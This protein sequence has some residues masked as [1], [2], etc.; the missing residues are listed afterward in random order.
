MPGY[1]MWYTIDMNALR[2]EYERMNALTP[3]QARAEYEAERNEKASIQ[4]VDPAKVEEIIKSLDKRGA[5][6]EDI[7]M[8]DYF[9]P[10]FGE[11]TTF[12]GIN[13]R[14]FIGNMNM[15]TNYVSE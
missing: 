11:R 2:K 6:V 9:N 4:Q 13:I 1:G 15:L 8:R 5:W 12:R 7:T 14:T 3:E 10:W